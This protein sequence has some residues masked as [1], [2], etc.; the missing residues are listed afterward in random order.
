MKFNGL[1][2]NDNNFIKNNIIKGSVN[3]MISAIFNYSLTHYLLVTLNKECSVIATFYVVFKLYVKRII[4][5]ED[6]FIQIRFYFE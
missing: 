2:K 3:I 4:L 6:F 5:Y 1:G